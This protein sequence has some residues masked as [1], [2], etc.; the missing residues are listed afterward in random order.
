[1][2]RGA[3]LA[4]AAVL[5]WCA[6][7]GN[8]L[9][10][11]SPELTDDGGA[12]DAGEVDAGVPDSGVGS[13]DA[14]ADSGTA[15][16]DSG[17]SGADAG[18]PGDCTGDIVCDDFETNAVGAAPANWNVVIDPPGVGTLRVDATH[19]FSGAK[20]VRV[21]SNLSQT[22]PHVQMLR[23]LKLPRN[24]FYG[25]LMVWITPFTSPGNHWNL[26]E[27]WGYIPGSVNRTLQEQEMYEYGGVCSPAGDLGAAYLNWT[28]DCC[29]PGD[30]GVPMGRWSCVE[31]H[32][33]GINNQMHFW[34]DGQAMPWRRCGSTTS[35]STPNAS[36]AQ[37]RRQRRT[38]REAGRA[39]LPLRPLIRYE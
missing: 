2:D 7:V 30:A 4:S 27:G 11:S 5:G 37:H 31:W 12:L 10:A 36:A 38:E 35:A 14:G 8:V 18:L 6:C 24:E 23:G 19:V 16:P 25:R 34:M 26:I 13:P 21:T 22:I 20:S 29:Q 1:M 28:T 17:V 32:F 39:D 9:P 3:R 33:D 15:R